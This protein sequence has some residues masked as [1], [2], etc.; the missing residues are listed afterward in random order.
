MESSYCFAAVRFITAISRASENKELKRCLL[1]SHRHLKKFRLLILRIFG[2]S[3][4]FSLFLSL[5]LFCLYLSFFCSQK[6]S[7]VL[8]LSYSLR[9]QMA[10][11]V[12]YSQKSVVIYSILCHP[13]NYSRAFLFSLLAR[14]NVI[15][16]G[17]TFH[18]LFAVV[19]VH[20]TTT[21]SFN[22]LLAEITLTL[23]H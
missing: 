6:T 12:A 23:S 8:V 16:S 10:W 9:R 3:F 1:D 7:W 11:K 22:F 18:L 21:R 14:C 19:F 15:S 13:F 20:S 4:S 5:S 17:C 2:K